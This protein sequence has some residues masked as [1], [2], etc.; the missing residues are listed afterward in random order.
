MIRWAWRVGL[1][2]NRACEECIQACSL[3]YGG[4]RSFRRPGL[5]GDNITMVHTVIECEDLDL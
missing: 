4:K 1:L 3:T 5:N 2:E